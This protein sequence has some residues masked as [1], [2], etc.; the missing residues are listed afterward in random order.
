MI[1]DCQGRHMKIM[2]SLDE[3]RNFNGTIQKRVLGM[4]VQMDE[5]SVFHL[6]STIRKKVNSETKKP[7]DSA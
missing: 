7:I 4:Q 2:R 5:V 1:S 3:I 6:M